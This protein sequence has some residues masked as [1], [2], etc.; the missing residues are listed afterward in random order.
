LSL[1]EQHAIESQ[2][3]LTLGPPGISP[4]AVAV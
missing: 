1:H 2:D 4:V 3:S